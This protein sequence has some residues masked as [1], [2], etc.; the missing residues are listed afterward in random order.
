V[1][2]KTLE[3]SPTI[4]VGESPLLAFLFV[5]FRAHEDRGM[6]KL[7]PRVAVPITPRTRYQMLLP[8]VSS[9]SARGR[10]R[11]HPESTIVLQAC[12]I[13]ENRQEEICRG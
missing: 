6:K 12:G 4:L 13:L 11:K 10:E 5:L 2:D 1:S 8:R 3:F 9:I 7:L